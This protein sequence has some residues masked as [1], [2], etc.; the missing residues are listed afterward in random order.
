MIK[1]V[2]MFIYVCAYA[3]YMFCSGNN[4]KTKYEFSPTKRDPKIMQHS[5]KK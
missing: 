2:Y 5:F 1:Y 3:I 4:D